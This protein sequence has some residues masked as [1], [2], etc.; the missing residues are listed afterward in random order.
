MS[1]KRDDRQCQP[2]HA[3]FNE[4]PPVTVADFFEPVE[5]PTMEAVE[6][7]RMAREYSEQTTAEY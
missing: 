6:S 1:D 3:G 7:R 5:Y 2:V 4:I